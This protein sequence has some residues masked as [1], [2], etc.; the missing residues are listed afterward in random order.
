MSDEPIIKLGASVNK[1]PQNLAERI[2]AAREHAMAA[3]ENKKFTGDQTQKWLNNMNQSLNNAEMTM[4][5]STKAVVEKTTLSQLFDKLFDLFDRYSFEYNQNPPVA[6][7]SITLVRPMGIKER[8]DY[9]TGVKTKFIHGHVTGQHFG[10]VVYAEDNLVAIY[11]I[12]SEFLLGFQPDQF[13][14]Y[15]FIEGQPQEETCNW[16]V[17]EKVLGP[18]DLPEFA[19]CLI[20][21]LVTVGIGKSDP[22][23]KF[24]WSVS[25][26]ESKPKAAS[27]DRNYDDGNPSLL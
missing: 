6:G 14:P 15:V 8:V 25:D 23:T 10:M 5:V 1:Q 12:P 4:K 24:K 11:I 16:T 9:S 21:H 20:G 7:M 26:Q 13:D 18:D 3:L 22:N 17:L 19:R 2:K 27:V